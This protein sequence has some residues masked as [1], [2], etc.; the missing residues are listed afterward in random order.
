MTSR[1]WHTS[2]IMMLKRMFPVL[3]NAELARH[4]KRSQDA[5]ESKASAMGLK[6]SPLYL[7]SCRVR[8]PRVKSEPKQSGYLAGTPPEKPTTT[9]QKAMAG[10][11]YEDMPG[12]RRGVPVCGNRLARHVRHIA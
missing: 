9:P 10:V 6:K 8:K 12:L 3:S 11:W 4:F 7:A 2:E 1:A 5:V